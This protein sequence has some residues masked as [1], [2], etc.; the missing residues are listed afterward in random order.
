M[1]LKAQREIAAL[2]TAISRAKQGTLIFDSVSSGQE[3]VSKLINSIRTDKLVD[4][5]MSEETIINY[6]NKRKEIL[7]KVLGEYKKTPPPDWKPV[8]NTNTPNTEEPDNDQNEGHESESDDEVDVKNAQVIKSTVKNEEEGKLNMMLHTVMVQ[9]TGCE[10][11]DESLDPT[12][13]NNKLKLSPNADK[14]IDN[15]NGLIKID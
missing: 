15:I 13:P 9:E 5:K 12:D 7:E 1:K 6:G 8:T 10:V 2:Y 14:R 11:S 4:K 3:T